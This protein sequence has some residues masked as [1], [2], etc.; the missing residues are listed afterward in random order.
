MRL[1]GSALFL[2]LFA[3]TIRAAASD[4]QTLFSTRCATCHGLDGK[5]GEH[6]PNISGNPDV[7]RLSDAAL[8]GIVRNGIA[9]AG[10]PA[11]GGSLKE[12][13][14][15]AVVLY[16]RTLQGRSGSTAIKGDAK[17]GEA[18]FFSSSARCGE[19]HMAGGRGGFLGANLTGYAQSHS[20]ADTRDAILHPERHADPRRGTVV[21]TT[22]SGRSVT[23]ILRNEDNFSVQ[24]QAADGKF[25]SFEKA[26]LRSID[27][28]ARSLMHADYGEKISSSDLD[29]LIAFLARPAG[30]PAEKPD[31][32]DE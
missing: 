22:R 14:I 27:R 13:E 19:C 26:Q 1:A 12:E 17:R 24:L 5:G 31:D 25:Y 7:Q 4:G 29:D 30:A 10:M 28:P 16:L 11:F 2:C 23:G 3:G 9:G 6:A 8:T 20:A 32:S 21:I 15:Q 18:I